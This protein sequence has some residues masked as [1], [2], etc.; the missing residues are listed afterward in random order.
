LHEKNFYLL[1]PSSRTMPTSF[2]IRLRSATGRISSHDRRESDHG[3]SGQFSRRATATAVTDAV[4]FDLLADEPVKSPVDVA[5]R[6]LDLR[7]VL[8]QSGKHD[9][10]E[11][12]ATLVIR[13]VTEDP[14]GDRLA[15]RF[16]FGDPVPRAHRRGEDVL[17]GR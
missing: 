11:P 13:L 12:Q 7:I 10:V 3:P 6:V 9:S 14:L 17:D 16:V 2:M 8:G 15:Q 1:V 5:K 4:L